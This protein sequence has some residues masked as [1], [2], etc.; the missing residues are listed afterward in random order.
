MVKSQIN[1]RLLSPVLSRG[2]FL[3]MVNTTGDVIRRLLTRLKRTS[4]G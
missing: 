4:R 1:P 3:G 2:Y